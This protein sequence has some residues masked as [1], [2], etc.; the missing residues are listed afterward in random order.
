MD[1]LKLK[2]NFVRELR[3]YL[4]EMYGTSHNYTYGKGD[5]EAR[6]NKGAYELVRKPINAPEDLSGFCFRKDLCTSPPFNKINLLED[7]IRFISIRKDLECRLLDKHK[8]H[9]YLDITFN[10]KEYLLSAHIGG[11]YADD[12]NISLMESPTNI[13][14]SIEKTVEKI[15]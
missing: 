14:K 5:F 13:L 6:K 9:D 12:I 10:K 4:Q 3:N 2:N 7:I 11:G 8:N 15:F 1:E